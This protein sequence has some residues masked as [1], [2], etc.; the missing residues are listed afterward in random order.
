MLVVFCVF[1]VTS[2]FAHEKE[3]DRLKES[4]AVLKEILATPD[5]GIPRD[6]LAKAECVPEPACSPDRSRSFTSANSPKASSP[7]WH[8]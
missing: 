1:F 4:Y 8:G 3:D 7:P 6:L 5:K 2:S